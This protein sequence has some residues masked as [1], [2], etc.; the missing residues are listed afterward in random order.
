MDVAAGGVHSVA[1][2]NDGT[3]VCWGDNTDGES[4]VPAGLRACLK[5]HEA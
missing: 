4:A 2:K 3:V 1:L 5:N